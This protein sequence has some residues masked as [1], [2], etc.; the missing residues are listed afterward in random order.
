MSDKTVS[1]SVVEA[2]LRRALAEGGA[3][4]RVVRIL[5]PVAEHVYATLDEP[6]SCSSWDGD[7]L[8]FYREV[9]EVADYFGLLREGETVGD[10]G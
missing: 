8:T 9:E 3:H 2:R 1:V 10:G 7:T 6:R 5:P 4:V